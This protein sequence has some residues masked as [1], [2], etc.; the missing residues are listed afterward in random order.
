ML[1]QSGIVTQ[2]LRRHTADDLLGVGHQMVGFCP[3]CYAATAAA[4]A[5]GSV[6]PTKRR[7]DASN[8]AR[9]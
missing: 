2:V 1:P 4:A 7:Q 8:S 9:T 6:S 3:F 5:G